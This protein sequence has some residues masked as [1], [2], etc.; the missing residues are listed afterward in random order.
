MADNGINKLVP[1]LLQGM[2]GAGGGQ[3]V[4]LS[5][6]NSSLGGLGAA[7]APTDDLSSLLGTGGGG[8]FFSGGG[9]PVDSTPSLY[10]NV[11]AMDPSIVMPNGA[12]SGG[13]ESLLGA[14]AQQPTGS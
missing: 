6:T 10:G 12:G 8:D 4:A 5:G 9:L 11:N 1:A 3:G 7:P 13:L 14:P 2:S